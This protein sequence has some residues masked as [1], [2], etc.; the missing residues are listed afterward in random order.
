MSNNTKQKTVIK[1]NI[2]STLF[3]R[4]SHFFGTNQK[5]KDQYKLVLNYAEFIQNPY[6]EFYKLLKLIG[7]MHNIHYINQNDYTKY[8]T[9]EECKQ[10]LK[11]YTPFPM[12]I[13]YFKDKIELASV[14]SLFKWSSFKD[15]VSMIIPSTCR[16][17]E[18]HEIVNFMKSHGY[19]GDSNFYH[20]NNSKEHNFNYKLPNGDLFKYELKLNNIIQKIDVINSK[21][22]SIND[23]ERKNKV[24]FNN[25]ISS[26]K[27]KDITLN[28][29]INALETSINTLT[30]RINTLE[31]KL[32]QQNNRINLNQ[33]STGQTIPTTTNMQHTPMYL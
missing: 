4:Y 3:N 14:I 2:D 11:K 16:N 13:V 12:C 28:N 1:D 25:E 18:M 22:A 8:A 15:V 30:T 7:D 5:F 21:I 29:R 32:N 6:G 19:V 33:L 31:N 26:L 24:S 17:N 20:D 23:N 27:Q 9:T 10:F